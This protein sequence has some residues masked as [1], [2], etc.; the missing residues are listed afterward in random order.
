MKFLTERNKDNMLF[1]RT[2][3]LSQG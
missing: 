1:P 3:G 2:R